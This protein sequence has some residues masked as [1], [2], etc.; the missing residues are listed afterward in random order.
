QLEQ[1]R[2]LIG[3]LI[4]QREDGM[5]ALVRLDQQID[6]ARLLTVECD[7]L[8]RQFAVM[9]QQD[10]GLDAG[11]GILGRSRIAD[12]GAE[13][14]VTALYRR[15]DDQGLALDDF[16]FPR[17]QLLR[18][19]FAVDLLDANRMPDRAFLPPQFV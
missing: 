10:Q 2:L 3:Y 11:F 1:G 17:R 4:D 15:V 6:G 18:P 5:E 13:R 9:A 16:G 12:G 14:L 19:K 8:L 7:D